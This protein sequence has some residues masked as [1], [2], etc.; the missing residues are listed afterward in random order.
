M[1]CVVCRKTS[2]AIYYCR[3][4][5]CPARVY[6]CGVDLPQPDVSVSTDD[7][8]GKTTVVVSRPNAGGNPVG[9]A[10]EAEGSGMNEKIKNVVEKI[11][12][13]PYT[14]EWIPRK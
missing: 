7:A 6:T 1:T 9:K 13:D 12:N 4:S 3:R 8:T 10:Y 2:R 11:V 14:A 5:D